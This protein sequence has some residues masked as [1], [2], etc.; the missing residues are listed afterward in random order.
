MC[1]PNTGKLMQ[2]MQKSKGLPKLSA[3]S[4]GFPLSWVTCFL[5]LTALSL[6]QRDTE[7]NWVGGKISSHIIH[8]RQAC[9]SQFPRGL[10]GAP[11]I[12]HSLVDSLDLSFR[13]FAFCFGSL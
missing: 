3:N 4:R 11:H 8:T 7:P 9:V 2:A 10:G 1:T 5:P 13:H 6:S 12:V